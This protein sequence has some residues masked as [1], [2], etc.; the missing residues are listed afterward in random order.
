MNRVAIAAACFAAVLG[1]AESAFSQDI[2]AEHKIRA[3]KGLKTVA[4]V[5]R[6]GGSLSEDNASTSRKEWSDRLE[7][8]LSQAIPSLG[9]SDTDRAW[10]EL[11][12]V[13][14][15]RGAALELSL[16]RWTTIV[17]SGEVVFSRVWTSGVYSFFGS[18]PNEE[19]KK[20]LDKALTS[21]AADY[22]RAN[23]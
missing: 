20:M 19:L 11:N 16:Y 21:F 2:L 4:I 9:R 22:L 14:S 3:L 12:L 15:D 18:A 10:L 8:M 13:T 5:V 17:D 1:I 6:P 23:R 7:V